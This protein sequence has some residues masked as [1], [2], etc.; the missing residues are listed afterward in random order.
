MIDRESSRHVEMLT[1]TNL[2]S[3]RGVARG[4]MERENKQFLV[5]QP[6]L[7]F[8]FHSELMNNSSQFAIKFLK[9]IEKYSLN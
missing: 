7:T 3:K 2:I 1:R 9:L 8:L 4:K 6:G 5:N